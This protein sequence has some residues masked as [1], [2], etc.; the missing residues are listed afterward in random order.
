MW[1]VKS[2]SRWPRPAAVDLN[3]KIFM[4]TSFPRGE[5]PCLPCISESAMTESEERAN[6][7]ASR[8]KSIVYLAEK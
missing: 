3:S 4:D 5:P 6:L 7:L 8:F 1:V 2:G